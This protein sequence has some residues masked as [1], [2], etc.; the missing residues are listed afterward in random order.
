M[1]KY[2]FAGD[3]KQKINEL[4]KTLEFNH[5]NSERVI[6]FRSFGSNSRAIARCYALSKIWQKALGTPPC[7]VVEVLS[8]RFDKLSAEEQIKVLI[9]E[10]L[11]IPKTFGGGFRYH[12]FVSQKQVE[13][14]YE[15]LKQ[16]SYKPF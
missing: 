13:Y 10:L 5:I 3:I 8:E 11:H 14:Y 2:L 6:C 12:D 1:V 9:H 15:I 4:I 7:Y 16:K